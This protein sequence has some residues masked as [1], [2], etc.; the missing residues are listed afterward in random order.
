MLRAGRGPGAATRRRSR[1]TR[2]NDIAVLR[3]DGLQARPRC[4]S[5]RARGAG[6]S[7]AVLGFPRNG[8]YDVRAGARRGD[9]PG[10]H[11]GRL[12]PGAGAALDH[13]SCAALVRS[14]NS[15]GPMVDGDGRVVGD[16][17][18]RDHERAAR[19][20]RACPTRSC[21]TRSRGRLR[22]RLAPAPAPADRVATLAASMA[23]TLVIAEKPSVGRDLTRALPGAFAKHEG[24]LESDHARRHVGGRPPRA[25]RRARRVRREVQEVADGRPADRARRVQARRA[26]RALAQADD[27]DHASCSSATTSTTSSTPATPGARAS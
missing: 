11:A 7:A 21:A 10:R 12:R 16:G 13:V 18:R 26:R 3:V 2:S 5:R 20:L 1:S 9:A 14:G 4:R 23:K 24:Y 15:G 22:P 6:T 19:R 25:A 27:G 17:L 8:P